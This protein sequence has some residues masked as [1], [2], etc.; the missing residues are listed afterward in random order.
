[1]TTWE[2]RLQHVGNFLVGG[3]GLIYGW[4]RY[5]GNAED[6][7]S[8]VGHPWEPGSRDAHILFAPL[9]VFAVGVIWQTHVWPK[10]QKS[11]SRRRK[12]GIML[13]TALLPMVGSG[14]L[15]QISVEEFW[16]IVW[17][18]IH[19]TVSGIWMLGYG[20]HLLTPK[21]DR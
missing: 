19:L 5:F 17:V 11:R 6:P 8:K 2:I 14:Y 10:Y 20:I 21:R 1:M 7:F 9:L 12:T 3:T 16:R 15:L 18:V 4:F 13:G